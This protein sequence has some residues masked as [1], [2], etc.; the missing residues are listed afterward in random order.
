MARTKRKRTREEIEE[1]LRDNDQ[2][3]ATP[4]APEEPAAKKRRQ[5]RR[6]RK[7]CNLNKE[8]QAL[9]VGEE[10]TTTSVVRS[11]AAVDA[12]EEPPAVRSDHPATEESIPVA[13]AADPRDMEMHRRAVNAEQ[14]RRRRAAMTASQQEQNRARDRESPYQTG[15][16]DNVAA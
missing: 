11:V 14:A 1:T 13:P 6:R 5:A 7:R 15:K 3:N 4:A 16:L 9:N 12:V 10:V 8:F 2:V